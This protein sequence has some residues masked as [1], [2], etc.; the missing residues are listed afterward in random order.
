MDDASILATEFMTQLQICDASMNDESRR[1]LVFAYLTQYQNDY[2]FDQ[3]ESAFAFLELCEC[4]PSL[5]PEELPRVREDV[6]LA[7]GEYFE[8]LNHVAT[9]VNRLLD[10]E[11]FL[12]DDVANCIN[13]IWNAHACNEPVSVFADREDRILCELLT[14]PI[15]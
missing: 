13:N 11:A 10:D 15:K 9:A 1:R 4:Q 12:I 14:T 5:L 7:L 8:S 3:L 6:A 2:W